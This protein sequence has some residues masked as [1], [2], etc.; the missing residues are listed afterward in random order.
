MTNRKRKKN[1][2][3]NT[4]QKAKDSATQTPVKTGDELRC[5]GRITTPWSLLAPILTCSQWK[6]TRIYIDIDIP[7]DSHDSWQH[8]RPQATIQAQ[9]RP[10]MFI[11]DHT[12]WQASIQDRRR[13]YKST[14]KHTRPEATIQVDKQAY[15]T[16]SDHTSWQ[17]SIQYRKRP[18]KLTSKHTRPEATIQIQKTRPYKFGLNHAKLGR[19]VW[20]LQFL[21]WVIF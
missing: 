3:H 13:P 11:S 9:K 18:Y 12:S 6:H 20:S 21:V 1:G 15:N 14:S 10:C 8:T 2:L 17:A 5:A 7:Y 4:S 19:K 16:G